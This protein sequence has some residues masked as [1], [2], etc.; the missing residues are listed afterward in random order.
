MH[1]NPNVPQ[2]LATD[3]QAFSSSLEV[4]LSENL[5]SVVLYGGIVKN[6]FIKETDRV[7]IM[8]VLKEVSVS[9][10]DTI[11][12]ALI[13]TKRARQIQLL[14]LTTSDLNTSTDVFPI[15]FLDMQQD[16]E[17][18]AG[19]DVV[20]EL[21]VSRDNLRFRCEQEIKNLMLRLRAMY[22]QSR[23]DNQALQTTLLKG[24]Y[25]FLQS[26]DA[27]AEL[28]TGKV[29]RKESEVLD[30]IES[31]GLD[32]NLMRSV[33]E[34]RSADKVSDLQTLQALYEKFMNMIVDAAEMADQI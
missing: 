27:L 14:T 3:I 17:V 12:E 15:K 9:C 21:E 28:K 19:D 24:Y 18:L 32:A 33:L 6:D 13:S 29:Y 34:L 7:K 5:V 23:K 2:K 11:S 31:I 22:M 25:S 10:L 1:M 4:G 20:K 30:G 16:Y 8:I 26:G